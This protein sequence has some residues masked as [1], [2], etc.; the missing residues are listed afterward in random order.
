MTETTL[1]VIIT[2]IIKTKTA[3][4]VYYAVEDSSRQHY[5]GRMESHEAFYMK[6]THCP[7]YTQLEAAA[8]DFRPGS[9]GRH[10]NSPRAAT[11]A[12]EAWLLKAQH[13]LELYASRKR[14]GS[15]AS[16]S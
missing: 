6:T 8:E 10:Y 4:T 12:R 13:G 2:A 15:R 7:G 9:G 3:V 1:A 16:S 11:M 14:P 5:T